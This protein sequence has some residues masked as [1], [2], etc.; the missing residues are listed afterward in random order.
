MRA[1]RICGNPDC[2]KP[3]PKTRWLYCCDRCGKNVRRK[4]Y[5]D[6]MRAKDKR[7]EDGSFVSLRS[8]QDDRARGMA[9]RYESSVI[10]KGRACH[11]CQRPTSDY[12]C[13][14]CLAKWRARHG[15]P[16]RTNLEYGEDF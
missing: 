5:R 13:S 2:G 15:V 10:A 4:A 9:Q 12:R 16:A 11:D 1:S 6:R 14:A 8:A 3:L 7:R